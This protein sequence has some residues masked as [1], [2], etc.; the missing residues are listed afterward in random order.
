M[1]AAHN[2][3][4]TFESRQ[5]PV[6]ALSDVSLQVLP[7]ERV[8]VLGESGAGKTTLCRTLVGLQKPSSGTV[9]KPHGVQLLFQD[10]QASLNPRQSVR[11]TLEE[12]LEHGADGKG[13]LGKLLLSVGL[14]AGHLKRKN[15]ELSGGEA[16]RVALAR[17]LAV[18]PS[19]IVAD[20][21]WSSLDAIRKREMLALLV[22]TCQQ[23]G[24]GLVLVSHDVPGL[25][26]ACQRLCV[27]YAGRIVEE[28]PTQTIVSAPAHP[29]TQ[30]LLAAVPT[31]SRPAVALA[32]EPPSA[33]HPL[34]GC[35]FHP[36][37]VLAEPRCVAE[38]PSV[39]EL[40]AGHSVACWARG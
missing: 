21:P 28:G 39:A 37:C 10:A 5:G 3:H 35:A 4:V 25:A 24:V 31:A 11:A 36:R 1:L 29:Y 32:G 15:R 27:M 9:H 8:G 2:L 34:P 14:A 20:E 12:A 23:R 22:N 6:V 16:Q 33:M 18:G 30:A 17:A 38:R 7:H 26:Q 40:G 19:Y 13:A